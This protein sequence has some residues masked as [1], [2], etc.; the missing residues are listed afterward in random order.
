MDYRNRFQMLNLPAQFSL[1]RKYRQALETS[2]LD[3]LPASVR[4]SLSCVVDVGANIGEWST[5]IAKLTKASKIIAFEPVPD[6]FKLLEENTKNFPQI[7][8]IN[9][10]VGS[11]VGQISMNVEKAHK[12]SSVLALRDELR[13]VHDITGDTPQQVIV[14]LTSLDHALRDYE[15][16]TLLK[17]DVQGYEPEVLVGAQAVLRRTKALMIEAVYTP[18]YHGDVQFDTLHRL[19]TDSTPLKLYG[20]SKPSCA[21]AT[22]QP[23]WADA[24]YV[25]ACDE[26]Q[27]LH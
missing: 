21:P 11:I 12:L 6:V 15:E 18:Y 2:R 14:P 7:S 3:M 5:G 1:N 9:S 27:T 26:S 25:Q 20:I 17:I 23:M 13:A 19:I 22:G 4:D 24:I 16:I 8:C 10:A